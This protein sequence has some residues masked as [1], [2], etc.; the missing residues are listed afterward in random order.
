MIPIDTNLRQLKHNISTTYS[1][2][3]D[4]IC[5]LLYYI[6]KVDT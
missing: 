1:N 5:K 6:N 2:Q 4:V 3:E